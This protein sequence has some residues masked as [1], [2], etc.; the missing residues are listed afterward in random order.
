MLMCHLARVMEPARLV[1]AGAGRLPRLRS[2]QIPQNLR[3]LTPGAGGPALRFF[4]DL[5]ARIV[6]TRGGQRGP[7]RVVGRGDQTVSCWIS[8][9]KAARQPSKPP[10]RL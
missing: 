5:G 8:S 6:R 4:D 3:S 7:A 2:G 1:L 9:G 10:L